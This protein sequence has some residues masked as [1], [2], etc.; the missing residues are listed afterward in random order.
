M[1]G[2]PDSLH[3]SA[4][5]PPQGWLGVKMRKPFRRPLRRARGVGPQFPNGIPSTRR[6]AFHRHEG[7]APARCPLVS[8][9]REGGERRVQWCHSWFLL[10]PRPIW[11]A[12]TQSSERRTAGDGARWLVSWDRACSRRRE[13]LRFNVSPPAPFQCRCRAGTREG[14]NVNEVSKSLARRSSEGVGRV[15]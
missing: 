3:Y 12:N 9:P 1:C 15:V 10:W 13:P 2:K 7:K 8:R 6:H 11:E 4:A 14:G 5:C